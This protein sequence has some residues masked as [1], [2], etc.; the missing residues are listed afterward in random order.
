MDFIEDQQHAVLVADLTQ[1]AQEFVGRRTDAALALHRLD[2]DRGRRVGDGSTHRIEIAELN[3]IEAR[4]LRAEALDIF[5][6]TAGGDGRDGAAV[7]GAFEGDDM[8]L[9]RMPL[10]KLIAPRRL[11]GAFQRFRTRVGEEDLVGERRFRQPLR[12]LLLARH[13]IEVGQMPDLVGLRLQFGDEM[14]MRMA[15]RVDSNA[16][17]EIEVALTAFRDQPDALASLEPQWSA[18]V[19][20]IKR[21]GLGHGHISSITTLRTDRFGLMKR[22]RKNQKCRLAAA[23]ALLMFCTAMSTK[24]ALWQ[25]RESACGQKRWVRRRLLQ[26]CHART[27]SWGKPRNRFL[28]IPPTLVTESAS[29]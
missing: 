16:G 26:K 14:G 22:V 23:R 29:H 4:R 17:G 11:D 2:Q 3:L 28:K 7:E 10:G 13:L 20:V 24:L 18:H 25:V 12:Q 5:L 27:A 19:G 8:E 9:F 1:P 21:R 6:L 15:E